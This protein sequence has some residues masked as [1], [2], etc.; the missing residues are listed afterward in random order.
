MASVNEFNGHGQFIDSVYSINFYID[1]H[2]AIPLWLQEQTI[3]AMGVS[4]DDFYGF[5]FDFDVDNFK[6]MINNYAANNALKSWFKQ[7]GQSSILSEG[8]IVLM[9]YERSFQDILSRPQ[10]YAQFHDEVL[11]CCNLQERNKVLN[12]YQEQAY[13]DASNG[14]NNIAYLHLLRGEILESSGRSENMQKAQKEYGEAKKGNF[15]IVSFKQE[16]LKNGTY[17]SGIRP[18][19]TIQ[20]EQAQSVDNSRTAAK[21]FSY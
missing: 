18:T 12:F 17:L 5:S 2:L 9:G 21:T 10:T 3:N 11:Q 20:I 15:D 7:D 19:N 6:E 13:K 16:K 1:N 8:R 14:G 4:K